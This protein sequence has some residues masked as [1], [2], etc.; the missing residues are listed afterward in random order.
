MTRYMDDSTTDKI[1]SEF[2]TRLAR[3]QPHHKLQAIVMLQTQASPEKPAR[4]LTRS[5]RQAM[6]QAMRNAAE[7][8]LVDIDSILE[9]HDGKRLAQTISA[10]GTVPIETT[11]AGVHALAASEYVKAIL[12]DQPISWLA[13]P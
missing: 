8:V 11:P 1:S 3:L 2:A 12:E 7:P 9:Q 13:K 5:E 4:R 10:V 6:I